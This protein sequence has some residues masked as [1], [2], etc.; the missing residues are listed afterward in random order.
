MTIGNRHYA[1]MPKPLKQAYR[2]A[3]VDILYTD[4]EPYRALRLLGADINKLM[5]FKRD[6][7]NQA[8]SKSA[9]RLEKVSHMRSPVTLMA[10]LLVLVLIL[11]GVIFVRNISR[12][13]R[14]R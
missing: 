6:I 2:F 7:R 5:S 13:M 10:V 4:D 3:V 9:K 14:V 1:S 8:E 12:Q 11:A